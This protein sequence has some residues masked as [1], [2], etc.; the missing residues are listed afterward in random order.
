MSKTRVEGQ[1]VAT[2]LRQKVQDFKLLVKLRL[3]LTVVFSA[4]MAF[5][6]A[7]EGPI[8]LGALLL[9]ALGGFFI[10]GG[11]NALNQ[12]IE[13]DFDK[14]MDR[15]ADRPVASGRMSVSDAV[16]LA[17]LMSL[18]GITMLGL[19]N[20]WAAFF[21]SLA[22]VSYAFLYTPM[23]RVSSMAIP[24]GAFPGALPMLIGCVAFQG[25]LT[26]LAIALFSIQFLWQFPHFWSI[27]W[28]GF[29]QYKKAGYRFI[30][31]QA[32]KRDPNLGL[33]S[34]LYALILVPVV[35]SLYFLGVSGITS[36]I[37]AAVLSVVYAYFGW[38]LYRKQDRKAALMLM[39]SSFFYLPLV[40]VAFWIDKI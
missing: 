21:G 36:A 2:G 9:L 4:V 31:E 18:G 6:I 7:S 17:G 23:K 11:A 20:P 28:L 27:G 22:L 13:K 14:L 3:N 39:F 26:W 16:L 35:F 12:V 32:G 37:I 40:L 24:I 15:T 19:F 29:D 10:T 34:G 33:F 38:N 25:T 5:I 8:N 1:I 30:P